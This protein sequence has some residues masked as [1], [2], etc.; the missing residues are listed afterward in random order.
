MGTGV[1]VG[2]STR[3]NGRR[4]GTD[5]RGSPDRGQGRVVVADHRGRRAGPD[6]RRR[7]RRRAGRNGRRDR[8]GLLGCDRGRPGPARSDPP[9]A[10]PRHPAGRRE[11]RPGAADAGL[12]RV[13]RAVRPRGGPGA[14]DRRRRD[15]ARALPQRVP[16]PAPPARPGC[17]ADRQRKRH[18]RHGGDPVRRQRPARRPGGGPGRRR[19]PR[20]AV[21]CGRSVHRQSGDA[22]LHPRER[23]PR[24]RRGPGRDLDRPDR[25]RGGPAAW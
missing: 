19:T 14:A 23:G 21:R 16:D 25:P 2:R 11:R 6:P 18:R 24:L 12:R 13:V 1:G 8:A 4:A 10:R 5:N 22:G 7:P 20:P 3:Q 17:R 15:P 9:T